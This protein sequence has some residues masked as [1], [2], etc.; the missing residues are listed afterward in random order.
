MAVDEGVKFTMRGVGGDKRKRKSK[1]K[2]GSEGFCKEPTI[3]RWK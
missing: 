3:P 2:R 1:M